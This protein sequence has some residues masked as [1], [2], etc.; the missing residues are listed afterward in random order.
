MLLMI[1]YFFN[2]KV[3]LANDFYKVAYVEVAESVHLTEIDSLQ[4]LVQ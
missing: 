4:N 1:S 2:I 3:K